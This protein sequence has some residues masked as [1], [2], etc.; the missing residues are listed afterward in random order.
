MKTG[1]ITIIKT[2]LASYFFGAKPGERIL[3]VRDLSESL[4][5]S[6]G[7]V[8]NTLNSMQEEG[9]VRIEKRGPGGSFL[10][11]QSLDRLYAMM[12]RGPMVIAMGLPMHLRFEGL[13]TAARK[14]VEQM[15]ID[16]YFIFIRGAQARLQA[17]HDNRCHAALMSCLSAEAYMK[18]ENGILLTLPETSWISEYGV[19]YR[20]SRRGNLRVG[21]DLRSYDHVHMTNHEFG[22]EAERV[23]VSYIHFMQFFKN[24]EIDA[25]VWNKDQKDDL[26]NQ[27][28]AYRPLS[29]RTDGKELCASFVGK[30][31]DHVT[32]K[33]L[34]VLE[35]T[36]EFLRIQ[37]QVLDSK[38]PPE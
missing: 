4:D 3:S 24:G 22:D 18:E 26:I 14:L 11:D 8:F 28:V 10:I 7:A 36:E 31:G 35:D 23:S 32:A 25:I 37:R 27:E 30:K 20:P 34:S 6:V 2:E 15:G 13:A 12:N 1:K 21:V 33:V 19:Y 29:K 5:A 17:L 38:I 9:L 16:I